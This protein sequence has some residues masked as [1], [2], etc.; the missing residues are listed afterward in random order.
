MI[1]I[2]LIGVGPHAKR[3]YLNYFKK[4][5]INLALVVEIESKKTDTQNYLKSNNFNHTK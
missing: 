4:Y 3:I 2:A 5:H 1:N